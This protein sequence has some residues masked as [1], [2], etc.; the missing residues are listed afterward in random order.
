VPKHGMT[1]QRSWSVPFS[2][3]RDAFIWPDSK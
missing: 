1:G 2:V 3:N